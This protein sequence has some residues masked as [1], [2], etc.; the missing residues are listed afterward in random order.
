MNPHYNRK[1]FQ[2]KNK[3]TDHQYFEG[4]YFKQTTV[5]GSSISFIP[6]ISLNQADAHAFIQVLY[7]NT[8]GQLT[9]HYFRYD[10]DSFMTNDDPFMIQ[11]GDNVFSDTG[12]NLN[13]VDE[14]ISIRGD[15]HFSQFLELETSVFS[16]NIMGFFSYIPKME[17]NHDIISM[18]H[19]LSGTMTY[20]SEKLDFNNGTGYIEKDWGT[21]FPEEYLWIQSNDFGQDHVSLTCSIATIP[22]KLLS[23]TGFFCALIIDGKHFR[24]ASYNGSKVSSLQLI[25]RG[26][27]LTIKG[28]RMTL[29]IQASSETSMALPSPKLGQMNQTIKEGL[30]GQV[31][32]QL[33]DQQNRII[34]EGNGRNSGIEIEFNS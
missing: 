3:K 12:I 9:S 6:G 20:N 17:C 2:G 13:L 10:L 31:W 11:I 28:K 26:V 19:K 34:Y 32:I 4:W 16:P 29:N 8:Q 7:L 25:D 18:K 23:F 30:S 24:F 27:K 33:I 15:L 5:I 14:A 1:Y 21:S 22:M